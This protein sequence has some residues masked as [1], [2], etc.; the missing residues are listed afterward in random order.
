MLVTV[1]Q[2]TL[3]YVHEAFVFTQVVEAGPL[4]IILLSWLYT[5]DCVYWFKLI[6][7]LAGCVYLRSFD[8]RCDATLR[9]RQFNSAILLGL[10][11]LFRR[12]LLRQIR[13]EY[14]II[15]NQ[16]LLTLIL[17]LPCQDLALHHWI[18]VISDDVVWMNAISCRVYFRSKLLII[19]I[20]EAEIIQLVYLAMHVERTLHVSV[21]TWG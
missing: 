17:L 8:H 20:A 6:V 2:I 14:G 16:F 7:H 11:Q 9:V 10:L 1:S 19:L 15:L 12:S 21:T 18:N 4:L 5:W 13:R 3:V